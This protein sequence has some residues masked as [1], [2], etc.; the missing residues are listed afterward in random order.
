MGRGND[1]CAPILPTLHH[2]DSLASHGDIC[3]RSLSL[4]KQIIE[5]QTLWTNGEP[6]RWD[7]DNTLSRAIEAISSSSID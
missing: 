4:P 5:L 7:H 2:R 3:V 1:L 6:N